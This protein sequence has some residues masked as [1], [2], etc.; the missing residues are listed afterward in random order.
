MEP[1]LVWVGDAYTCKGGIVKL[2]VAAVL[3]AGL[4][5]ASEPVKA[6]SVIDF[7]SVAN[8]DNSRPNMFVYSGI[9]FL[10]QW[11]CYGFAQSPYTPQSGINR[12]YAVLNGQNA[13]SARFKFQA[14]S[15][16]LGAW[17]SGS[18]TNIF[19]RLFNGGNLV[20]TSTGS[21]LSSTPLFLSSGYNGAVDEVEV[22]G[23]DVQWVMDDLTFNATV[24]PEP[25]SMLLLG[26]GLAGIGAAARRRRRKG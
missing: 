21:G 3:L 20:Y 17:F 24:A 19:Y 8:C 22:S 10:G 18:S 12:L 9:D 7:E 26:S 6:Q 25:A 4:S 15:S 13:S 23:S 5:L 14:P 16:F 2:R 1:G 11:T